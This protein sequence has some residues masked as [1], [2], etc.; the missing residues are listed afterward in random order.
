MER[1][2]I[3][4]VLI[5]EPYYV[6]S[7]K[8]WADDICKFSSHNVQLLTLPGRH[9][10]WRMHG[11]AVTLAQR[12]NQLAFIP[13][14][15]IVTDMID[16]CTFKSL[17]HKDLSNIPIVIYFHENQLTYPWSATDQD[18]KLNR[19]RN[20][21]WI[22]YV[23]ALAADEIWFNSNYHRES[24][25]SALGP[26]LNAF[27]DY[28]NKNSVKVISDKSLTLFIG[29]DLDDFI[30]ESSTKKNKVPT[31]L[32]NHRWEYDKNP[33]FFFETLFKLSKSNSN[34]HL[35]ILGESYKSSPT[36]FDLART[37]LKDHIIHFGFAP[38]REIYISLVKQSDLL[39][40]TS[41]QDFF[42]ISTI[43]A[44]AAGV[45][46]LLPNRL[47]YRDHLPPD[48]FLDYYYTTEKN[49]YNILKEWV[50]VPDHRPPS[51]T[52]HVIN[53]N[54]STMI[55]TYD[56]VINNAILDKRKIN[57]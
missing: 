28:Q 49:A 8:V 2:S 41:I 36:I 51:L 42:G 14:I 11:A 46:P 17:I 27:P 21:A 35:I 9:W 31:L 1:L 53:Y 18:V 44:I 7:H 10:K 34:F 47:A 33:K 26:F 56:S 30:R 24:F 40:V 38:N 39:F 12:Y 4:N 19:D 54:W 29:L 43:E 32:W 22:N 23:S 55:N 50:D 16:L 6:G 5:V 25:T 15:I 20:Y 45:T 13:D 37:E 52:Q 48:K 3:S 57:T